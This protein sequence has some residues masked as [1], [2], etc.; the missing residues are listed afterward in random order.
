MEVCTVEIKQIGMLDWMAEQ[1]A[2]ACFLDPKGHNEFHT[3]NCTGDGSERPVNL[4]MIEMIA[5]SCAD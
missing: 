3:M 5:P 1:R 2:L 4:G